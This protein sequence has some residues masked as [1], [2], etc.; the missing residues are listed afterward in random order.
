M[1]KRK[2]NEKEFVLPLV[3][4]IRLLL[5]ACTIGHG[6]DFSDGESYEEQA[7]NEHLIQRLT[8][9]SA[10]SVTPAPPAAVRLTPLAKKKGNQNDNHSRF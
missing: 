9:G 2:I 4:S 10:V 3:L 7:E 6:L 8:K 1:P 5:L